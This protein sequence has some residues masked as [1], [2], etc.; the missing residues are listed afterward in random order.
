MRILLS[1]E[2]LVDASADL[3][4]AARRIVF[5]KFMNCGQTCVAPDYLLCERSVKDTLMKELKKQIKEQFSDQPLAQ[6][7][8]GKIINQ[9]H[10]ERIL[11]LI[12]PGKI[13]IGGEICAE[14]LRIAPTVLDHVTWE[15]AVMQ[16]EI[17]GP[18]LPVL[19]YDRP[20]ELPSLINTRDTPLALYLFSSDQRMI[21]FITARIPYGGGCINDTLIH[22]ATCEMGFGGMG[23]SGMGSYHGKAGFDA[24]SHYKS[25]VDKKTWLNLGI[26]YRPYTKKKDALIR[27]FER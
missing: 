6:P 14:T 19:T 24:F 16:E 15:D 23:E 11:A 1:L 3:P 20:E 9:K 5:G 21:R 18:V 17:F 27:L 10:F 7:D 4:L 22:L 25:I 8:Y 13:A 2:P 26:R 12:E